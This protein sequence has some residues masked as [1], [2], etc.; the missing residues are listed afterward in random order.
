MENKQQTLISISRKFNYRASGNSMRRYQVSIFN[1]LASNLFPLIFILLFPI[2]S[3]S[4]SL[5]EYLEQAASN[6]PGLQARYTDFEASMQRIPQAKALPDATISFGYFVSPVETRVGPQRAKFSLMQM[7]PWF[8]SQGEKEDAATLAAQAKFQE[9]LNAKNELFLKVKVSYYT[10]YELHK[11]IQLQNDNLGILHTYKTL[12]TTAFSNAEGSMVD[13]IRVDIK[14][15]DAKTEIRLLQD[16]RRPLV[17]AFNALLNRSDSALVVIDQLDNPWAIDVNYQKDSIS[18][19]N[20]GLTALELRNQSAISQEKASRKQ[21]GP[22]FGIGLDYVIVD[23][24]TDID[25]P[26]NGKDAFMPM[27][28]MSLPIFRG[29]YNATIK[30]S[31]LMQSSF[32]HQRQDLENNLET[33]YEMAYFEINKALQLNKLY[34]DQIGNSGQNFEDI[35][36]LQQQLLKYELAIASNTKEFYIALAELD[37]LLAK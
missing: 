35:L 36:A 11:M 18:A 3:N 30:E 10:L 1:Y 9:F 2:V 37:F 33:R 26:D 23:Q 12:A 16:K 6:N 8:G 24:R 22:N 17:A 7:F 31:Q 32:S 34:E 27:I 19:N 4:Q 20:P 13:V 28:S 29:K 5:E 15:E 14:I 25:V 21:G